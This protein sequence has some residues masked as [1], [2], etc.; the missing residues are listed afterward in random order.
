MAQAAAVFHIGMAK[1]GPPLPDGLSPECRDFLNLCFNRSGCCI[2]ARSCPQGTHRSWLVKVSFTEWL[3][4][5]LRC[6]K[7]VI[8]ANVTSDICL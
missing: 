6:V 8:H 2:S 5:T 4:L 1:G 3:C 7:A